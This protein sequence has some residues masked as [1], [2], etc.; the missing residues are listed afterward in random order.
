M[1]M[2]SKKS[3]FIVWKEYQRRVEVFAPI[4]GAEAYYFYF[5]WES[6]S[7]LFKAFSY[8][9]KAVNTLKCLFQNKPDLVFVQ[10][11]P[12]PALYCAAFYS[13]LTGCEYVSDCHI[14]ETNANWLDWIYVKELLAGGDVVVHNE[15]LVGQIETNIKVKPFV[16]RDGVAKRRST[17]IGMNSLLRSLGLSP[18]AYVIFPCS[19]SADEPLLE[20]I[21]AARLLP[22][23][24]FVMTWYLEKLPKN[25]RDILPP[26]VILTGFLP[27]RDFNHLFANAGVALV[28]TKHEAVQLSGMQEAMAFEVPAVVTDL[29]TT[30]FLYRDHP[31]YVD[32]TSG[33]IAHGISRAF[34]NR[35]ELKTRMK[36]LRIESETLFLVQANALKVAL[37][38]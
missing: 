9:L 2:K 10:F 5:P 19:F 23:T 26:N 14:G 1:Y 18:G 27:V 21:E 7:I 22:E 25:L 35:S 4:L 8:F 33:S 29:K 20:V 17:E 28:L 24:K 36:R 16:I 12:A 30:R 32:N 3:V 34:Q 31:I 6:K 11:P 13:W 15:Y 37:N 38:I